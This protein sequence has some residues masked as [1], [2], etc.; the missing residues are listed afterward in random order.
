MQTFLSELGKKLAERWLLTLAVPGLLYCAA[1]VAAHSLGHHPRTVITT[2]RLELA[3]LSAE[4]RRDPLLAVLTVLLCAAA[5]ALLASACAGA[6]RW[7]WRGDWPTPLAVLGRPLRERRAERWERRHGEYEA[8][9][10]AERLGATRSSGTALPAVELARRR[11]RVGLA[12]PSRPTWIGDRIAAV[13]ALVIAE[14]GVDLA[15]AWPRLWLLVPDDQRAEVR[16]VWSAFAGAAT[17]LAWGVLYTVLGLLSW[18]FA[19][20]GV[21]VALHGWYRGR[22]AAAA[23]GDLIESIA[24]LHLPKLAEAMGVPTGILETRAGRR[25]NR[26]LHKGT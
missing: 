8:A 18:P 24:D 20:L 17:L 26:T 22:Q 7:L 1:A 25:L 2:L 6:V 11:N 16:T 4:A 3:S 10:R 23:Y 9:V 14:Y 21:V 12:P 15:V 19:I 13:Q 5:A